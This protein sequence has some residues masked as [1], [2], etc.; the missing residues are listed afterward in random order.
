[1]KKLL[2]LIL[3]LV[4]SSLLLGGIADA[5]RIPAPKV[6][7]IAYQGLV[8]HAPNIVGRFGVVEAWNHKTNRKVWEEESYKVI[9]NP[10]MEADVQ[11]VFISSLSIDDGKLVITN[12]KGKKFIVAI[13]KEILQP[14]Q[15]NFI[16][17]A[18]G[19]GSYVSRDF[20]ANGK[21]IASNVAEL[22][23]ALQ[24]QNKNQANVFYEFVSD[25]KLVPDEEQK[26]R[27]AFKESVST[28]EHFWVP[29]STWSP[30]QEIGPY[31]PGFVDLEKR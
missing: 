14:D 13:P 29:V 4:V 8:F 18:Y 9:I 27:E 26:I 15:S 2:F 6:T 24:Q 25:W 10:L 23:I 11:W 12:E 22:R 16:Q 30:G 5:K 20:F 21:K 7:P 3:S 17:I 31:G 28:L 19:D 1:M